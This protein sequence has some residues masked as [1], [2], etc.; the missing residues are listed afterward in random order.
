MALS[1]PNDDAEGWLKSTNGEYVLAL[2]F[3]YTH[4]ILPDMKRLETVHHGSI[5]TV[6]GTGDHDEHQADVS[7]SQTR[8]SKPIDLWELLSR[9]TEVA[10]GC[11]LHVDSVL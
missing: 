2:L 3:A 6:G 9:K 5:V 10:F 4:T 7:P 1:R 11:G 8:V